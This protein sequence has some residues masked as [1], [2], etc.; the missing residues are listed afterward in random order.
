[1]NQYSLLDEALHLRGILI[2]FAT[3]SNAYL[4][5][6]HVPRQAVDLIQYCLGDIGP[7]ARRSSSAVAAQS[8]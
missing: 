7:S 8:N 5:A 3:R 1:M 4:K 2:D 6:T